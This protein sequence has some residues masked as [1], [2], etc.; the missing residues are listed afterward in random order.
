MRLVVAISLWVLFCVSALA[1]RIL[2]VPLDSRP[3]AGQFAQM[4][5]NMA[6]VQVRQPEYSTLGRFTTPGDPDAILDWLARQDYHDVTA[7]IASADMIAYG[8]LIASRTL[9]T[10]KATAKSRLDRLASIREAHPG[11]KFYVFSAVMR[12]VPTA[13][14]RTADW[15]IQ[16]GRYMELQSRMKME[17]D[18]AFPPEMARMKRQVPEGEIERYDRTRVRNLEI[19]ASL[20]RM[21]AADKFDYV[22][23]GQDD[24]RPYGP[25][26][27]E[28]QRLKEIAAEENVRDKAYFCEGIDQHANVLLSRALLNQNDWHPRIRVVYSDPVKRTAYAAF[29]SKTIDQSLS[30]QITASGAIPAPEYQPYDF[31]LYVNVPGRRVEPFNQFV[32]QLQNDIDQGFPVAVADINLAKDGTA[33]P[34]LFKILSAND[35]M[36]RILAFAGWNTAGNTMGTSIPAANVYLLSRRLR[37]DPLERELA[38]REFL[39]HR[40]VNDYAYHKFTRPQAY[41]MIDA[42]HTATR[43]ETYGPTFANVDRFVREDVKKYLNYYWQQEFEGKSFFAGTTQYKLTE[44]D[45]V[46]VFLP[47]PRAYEVRLEF[48]LKAEPVA[49]QSK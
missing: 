7:V 15:R 30:D 45:N 16:L 8:G 40:F 19:N 28:T 12:L 36:V 41:S 5:G 38:R 23:F 9:D 6:S 13:T 33:D 29:E 3:A 25:H 11:V 48:H 17:P 14:K 34:D 22:A 10:T 2:L 26:V 27:W 46:K 31:S 20:L 4:I 39:L 24:A 1:E 49:T 37:S 21:L 32:V 43:E 18:P 42:S 35:R 44:V 47:W